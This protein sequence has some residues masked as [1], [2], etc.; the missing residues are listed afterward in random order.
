MIEIANK[1]NLPELLGNFTQGQISD[2][3]PYQFVCG[4]FTQNL[5]K[6]E[7]EALKAFAV[8]KADKDAKPAKKVEEEQSADAPAKNNEADELAA[9][10]AEYEAYPSKNDKKGRAMRAKIKELEGK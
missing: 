4:S 8:N 10:K 2:G 1:T 7:W 3:E 9:L 6:R 5:V